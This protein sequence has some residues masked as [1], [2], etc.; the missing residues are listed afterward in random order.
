MYQLYKD[1]SQALSKELGIVNFLAL[2]RLMKVSLGMGLGRAIDDKKELEK[3]AA[4]LALI[5]GQK[6]KITHAKK[7]ISAFKLKIGDEIGLV[8]TL[9]GSRMY[10]FLDKLFNMILPRTRDFKGLPKSSFDGTGNF[11]IGFLEQTV[12]P[13]IN[14]ANVDKLRGLQ[15]TIVTTARDNKE[16]EALLTLLGAPFEKQGLVQEGKS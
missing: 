15:V 6:P 10:E 4:E 1:K 9:R 16:A 11:S 12:F 3:A 5:A 8:V 13:E 2:P 7:A 14:P